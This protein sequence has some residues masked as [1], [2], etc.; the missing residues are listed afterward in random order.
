MAIKSKIKQVV[1]NI[2]NTKVKDVARTVV[3]PV[4]KVGEIVKKKWDINQSFRN[5]NSTPEKYEAEYSKRMSG[6]PNRY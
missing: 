2:G 4:I 6:K 3:A 5:K 1:S